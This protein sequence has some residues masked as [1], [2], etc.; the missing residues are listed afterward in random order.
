[1]EIAN[2][3]ISKGKEDYD[4]ID[5]SGKGWRLKKGESIEDLKKRAK[6]EKIE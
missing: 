6:G 2:K 3:F 5:N 1:M 4:Y